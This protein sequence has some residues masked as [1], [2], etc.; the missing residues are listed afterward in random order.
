MA[1]ERNGVGRES[2]AEMLEMARLS[3]GEDVVLNQ[4]LRSKS[5]GVPG[6]FDAKS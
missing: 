4:R 1:R 5:R 6:G 2:R 3:G